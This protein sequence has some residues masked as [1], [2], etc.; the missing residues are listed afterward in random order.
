M[1]VLPALAGVS[2]S[3]VAVVFR[4][5]ASRGLEP[6][7]LLGMGSVLGIAVFSILA[8]RGGIDL[9]ALP[10][11][12]WVLPVLAG[13]GQY[14]TLKLFAAGMRMGPISAVWCMVSLH[15]VPTLVFAA[16]FLSEDLLPLQY[17]GI[18]ASVLCVL[19][20]SANV[21]P[22]DDA[23]TAPALPR[24]GWRQ[25]LLY[26]ALLLTL[27]LTNSVLSISQR[28]LGGWSDA[29]PDE[30]MRYHGHFLLA[31]CYLT[32]AVLAAID[33]VVLGHRL[34]SWK[35]TISLSLLLAAGSMCGLALL[36]ACARSAVVFAVAG[37][38]QIL[39]V[40]LVSVTAFRERTTPA[41]YAT[42]ISGVL[43]VLL[44]NW[45]ALAASF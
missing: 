14:V 23:A 21:A 28:I 36:N 22:A 4:L 45:N 18:G 27:L 20:A 32:I 34:P 35:V 1:L 5:G 12:L 29:G 11:A 42:I 19:F 10:P 40:A 39:V 30:A 17:A 9:S 24:E 7:H 26:L 33:T 38:M 31:L 15:F 13:V 25:R 16:A 6:L 44:G 8:W 2:F 37:I 43:A 3:L 41:W